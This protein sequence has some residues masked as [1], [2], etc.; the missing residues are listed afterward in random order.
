[1]NVDEKRSAERKLCVDNGVCGGELACAGVPDPSRD[2]ARETLAVQLVDRRGIVGVRR[3]GLLGTRG[4]R[5]KKVGKRLPD[6]ALDR[7]E[8]TSKLELLAQGVVEAREA[9]DHETPVKFLHGVA[10]QERT[11]S[12]EPGR[13]CRAFRRPKLEVNLF[14]SSFAVLRVEAQQG[15][16]ESSGSHLT[17]QLRRCRLDRRCHGRIVSGLNSFLC[18]DRLLSQGERAEKRADRG[19]VATQVE[20]LALC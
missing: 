18:R 8:E 7:C 16:H 15:H 2:D 13:S 3:H 20:P 6:L 1:M 17:S 11:D 19:E 9:D 14:A 5:G 4:S 12:R 10:V